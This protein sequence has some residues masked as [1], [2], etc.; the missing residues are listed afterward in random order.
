MKT[1]KVDGYSYTLP[2]LGTIVGTRMLIKLINVSGEGIVSYIATTDKIDWKD[3][4]A[5]D[6]D[7]SVAVQAI[8]TMVGAI[9]EREIESYLDTLLN[10][11][12]CDGADVNVNDHFRGRY[13]HMLKVLW[14]V[15]RYNYGDF[16]D[17]SQSRLGPSER[18]A[19]ARAE[20]ANLV[21][22]SGR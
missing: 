17:S 7:M 20:A 10:G 16:F 9:D 8:A 21:K 13:R 2:L 15:I 14:E 12:R 5:A 4:L 18:L 19:E 6:I 1:V 11:L 3:F 22:Q